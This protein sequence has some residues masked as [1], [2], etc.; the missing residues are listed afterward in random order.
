MAGQ[1]LDLL[2]GPY[3]YNPI[4]E[5][6]ETISSATYTPGP[7]LVSDFDSESGAEVASPPD[8]PRASAS[9]TSE[10]PSQG[11]SEADVA[12]AAAAAKDAQATPDPPRPRQLREHTLK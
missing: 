6:A 11:G 7:S 1:T 5:L 8:L 12:E 10:D 2:G 3:A 9:V 4:Q